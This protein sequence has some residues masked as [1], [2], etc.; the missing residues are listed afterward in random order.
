MEIILEITFSKRKTDE[1][2]LDLF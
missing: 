1:F 2:F